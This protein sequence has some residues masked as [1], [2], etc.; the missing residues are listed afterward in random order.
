M[1]VVDSSGWLEYFAKGPNTTFFKAALHKTESL[2]VPTICIYEV[3]KWIVCQRDDEEA[4]AAIAWMTTAKVVD[5]NQEIAIQTADF[6]REHKL[7]MADSIIYATAR[8]FQATLWT[9]DAHFSGLEGVKFIENR[10]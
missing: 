2:L 6:S 4:L 8:A 10:K 9:Q 3:Y 1:N 5:L 7:A